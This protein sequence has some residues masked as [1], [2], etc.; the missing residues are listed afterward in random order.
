[1]LP[2]RWLPTGYRLPDGTVLG[3]HL[4]AGGQWQIYETAA[5]GLVLV[6]EQALHGLW[7]GDGLLQ[8]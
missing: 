4:G 7:L 2:D 6:A 1:M 3:R 5:G 8:P